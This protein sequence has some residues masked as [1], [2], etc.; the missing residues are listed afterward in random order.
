MV[1]E[2]LEWRARHLETDDETAERGRALDQRDLVAGLRE[3]QGGGG[4]GD[5]AADD[6]DAAGHHSEPGTWWAAR[7]GP[8]LRS[9]P[10]M[11][12]SSRS[13]RMITFGSAPRATPL[14]RG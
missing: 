11:K 2:A 4:A 7:P 12:N 5:A 13:A 3:A 14:V 10:Y 6:G 9:R 8:A 1:V